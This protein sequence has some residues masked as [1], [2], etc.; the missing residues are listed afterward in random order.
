MLFVTLLKKNSSRKPL[1]RLLPMKSYAEPQTAPF[2]VRWKACPPPLA[3]TFDLETLSSTG[4]LQ[5]AA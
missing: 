2:K 5:D 3:L 4:G 1:S